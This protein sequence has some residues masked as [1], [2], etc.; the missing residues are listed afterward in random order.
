A[1]PKLA[2]AA[3]II[4]AFASHRGNTGA[5]LTTRPLAQQLA[6]LMAQPPRY[7]SRSVDVILALACWPLWSGILSDCGFAAG[8]A[9]LAS[10]S[11]ELGLRPCCV[12]LSGYGSG[13]RCVAECCSAQCCANPSDCGFGSRC[14]SLSACGSGLRCAAECCSVQCCASPSGY[15]SGSRCAA[16]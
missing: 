16:D 9:S 4:A 14:A 12:S 3:T 7:G 10:L 5:P 11:S 6:Q 8:Y 2:A 15:G 1:M 13:S